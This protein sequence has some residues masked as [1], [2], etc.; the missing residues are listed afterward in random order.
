MIEAGLVRFLSRA[1]E[2]LQSGQHVVQGYV[3]LWRIFIFIA[4][5]LVVNVCAGIDAKSFFSPKFTSP[6]PLYIFAIQAVCAMTMYQSCKSKDIYQT[7]I[8]VILYNNIIKIQ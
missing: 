3:S 8:R 7:Y 2:D 4:G 1:K 5:A 6:T